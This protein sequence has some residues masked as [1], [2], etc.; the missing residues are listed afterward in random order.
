MVLW[1]GD[2]PHFKRRP[3]TPALRLGQVLQ[4]FSV[5]AF[6]ASAL[7][8]FGHMW[9]LYAMWTLV[10][11]LIVLSNLAG[12][13]TSVQSG[14]SLAVIGIGAAGCMASSAHRQHDD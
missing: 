5:R 3:G 14:L 1:M 12:A 4:A 8:C 13:G 11:S 2:G 10:P 6:R 7:G 9:E